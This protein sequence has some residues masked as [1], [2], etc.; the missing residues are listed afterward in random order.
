MKAQIAELINC[1][2]FIFAKN[3]EEKATV[4]NILHD[5]SDAETEQLKELF[6]EAGITY[7]EEKAFIIG[8]RPKGI[9]GK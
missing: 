5:N 3:E 6:D 8:A 7:A 4:A 1:E 9:P 2:L